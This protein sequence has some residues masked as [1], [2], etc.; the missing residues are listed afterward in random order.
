MKQWL[1]NEK[2]RADIYEKFGIKFSRE[3]P[4]LP[5]HL[6]PTIIDTPNLEKYIELAIIRVTEPASMWASSN[7]AEKQRLQSRI[8]P[9]GIYYNKKTHEPRTLKM[10]KMFAF[11][12]ICF[13]KAIFKCG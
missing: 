5:E 12:A 4:E 7:Y 6:Q 13:R 3:K 11:V 9:E 1:R 8:F 10:N 2:V